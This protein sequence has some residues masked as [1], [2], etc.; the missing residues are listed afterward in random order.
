MS[1]CNNHCISLRCHAAIST[2]FP[3]DMSCCNNHCI[4]LR[5]HFPL[6]AYCICI[7]H[8]LHIAYCICILHPFDCILHFPS[9]C[10]AAIIT[11]FT[12]D[13]SWC[14]IT[15]DGKMKFPCSGKIYCLDCKIKY[16]VVSFLRTMEAHL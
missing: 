5:L 7:L 4:S 6:I 3:F 2:A 10:H 12:F 9:I 16:K 11:A 8:P 13:M 15:C 14:N 1:C